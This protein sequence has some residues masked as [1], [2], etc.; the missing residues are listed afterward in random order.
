M[1]KIEHLL[2]TLFIVLM[3]SGCQGNNSESQL[4]ETDN[5]VDLT[6]ELM[7]LSFADGLNTKS[8]TKNSEVTT[9]DIRVYKPD[10]SLLEEGNISVAYPSKVKNGVDVGSFEKSK[11]LLSNGSAKFSYTAPKD[12][13][14]RVEAGDQS[15]SFTFYLE[16]NISVSKEFTF[17][18]NPDPEQTILTSYTLASSFSDGLVMGLNS[19][20]SVSFY[21]EDEDGKKIQDDW[22]ESI[23]VALS[24]PILAD[25]EDVTGKKEKQLSFTEDNDISMNIRTGTTS[26][27][28][29]VEVSVIFT[30][31]NGDKQSIEEVFNVV[32]LSGPPS[33][34]SFSYAGTVDNDEHDARAKFV[35]SWIVTVTDRYNNRVN[36]N[37]SISMGAL[38]GYVQDAT[39]N[40]S[41]EGNYL[42]YKPSEAQGISSSLNSSTNRFS[43][44][45]NVFGNVDDTNNI[46]VTFGDGYTYQSSG[47]WDINANT[48][49]DSILDLVDDYSAET[50][51]GMGFAVGHNFK[52]DVCRE[53]REWVVNVY[54]ENDQY[55]IDDTGSVRINVE[56]DYYMIGKDIMLWANL[57]GM[58]HS[59]STN[60]RIG[61]A[62][63]ITLRG[64]DYSTPECIVPAF[65]QN[66]LCS[67]GIDIANR[68]KGLIGTLL[69]NAYV[70]YFVTAGGKV[71]IN[72]TFQAS[73]QPQ[74]C[75]ND[76]K[77]VLHVYATNNED[78]PGSVGIDNI[79][80][81]SEF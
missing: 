39:Q 12:L 69:R 4:D 6:S 36:T 22:I 29:P 80:I 71:S 21:V 63:K 75:T 5:R 26:G 79:R 2:Y 25:L 32:V 57:I 78:N 46:L 55:N 70:K 72:S 23:N 76:G 62:Q 35:E 60:I 11:I 9:I 49:S 10:N 14:A 31:I 40:A 41:N 64:K 52:Q 48:G 16:S 20:A 59:S 17:T 45:T 47:K 37:S 73:G 51:S 42:Y 18:Y 8:L 27:I 50:I 1:M 15:S 38:A 24:N 68:E 33:A 81:Q 43:V 65:A 3:I 56:Y 67:F 28:L 66:Y 19:S 61:E 44:S 74:N 30:D 7:S 34:M 13:K 53:G 77:V 54:P 58:Q